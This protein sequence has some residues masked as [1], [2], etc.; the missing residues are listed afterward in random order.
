MNIW[1]QVLSSNTP[2][3]VEHQIGKFSLRPSLYIIRNWNFDLIQSS[4]WISPLINLTVDPFTR[5]VDYPHSIC[6]QTLNSQ[7]LNSS[8]PSFR[9][10]EWNLPSTNT[11]AFVRWYKTWSIRSLLRSQSQ[12]PSWSRHLI[13]SQH[14]TRPQHL[15]R[16][17]LLSWTQHL[18][19]LRSQ[20]LSLLWPQHLSLPWLLRSQHL[21]VLWPQHLS[22][23]WPQHL[24]PPW[25]QLWIFNVGRN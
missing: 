2:L 16:S 25:P 21:S 10:W 19:L 23:L 6:P 3:V 4:S 1:F 13:R 5:S 20:H 9:R 18:S 14:L 15:F 7:A 22:V 12:F 17:C 24:S 11:H 8:A